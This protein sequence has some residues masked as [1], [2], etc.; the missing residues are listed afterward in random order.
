[1]LHIDRP[2]LQRM[3]RLDLPNEVS[4]SD[5]DSVIKDEERSYKFKNS[6]ADEQFHG[7]GMGQR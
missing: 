1:M 4:F 6:A 2:S 7:S 3:L 5:E